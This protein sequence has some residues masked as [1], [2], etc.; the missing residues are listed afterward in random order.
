MPYGDL[1]AFLERLDQLGELHRIEAPVDTRYE[2]GAVCRRSVSKEGPALWFNQPRGYQFPVIANLLATRKR[3][4][5]ALETTPELLHT[6][7]LQRTQQSLPPRL[8][9]KGP[10]Q[11]V[12]LTGDQ[13]DLGILPVPIWNYLDG[14]PYITFPCQISKDP[15][16][17]GRNASMYRSQVH[18]KDAIGILSAPYRHLA[19]QRAR[20]GNQPFPVAIALG[21][22]PVIHIA[23]TAC[24]AYGVDELAMAGALAGVPV[25]LV[26]CVTIP[27]EVPASAEIVLEG[28]MLPGDMMEEGPFGEFTGYFGEKM[29]RPVIRIRAITHRRDAL[30][31]GSYVGKPPTENDLMLGIPAEAEVLRT[32]PLPGIKKVHLSHGGGG[33]MHAV[34]AL[35]QP[36]AGY[37]K[38]VGLSVLGTQPGRTMKTL[39]I[40]DADLDPFNQAEVRWALSTHVRP[41]HDVEIIRDLSGIVLDPSLPE[42]EK[43]SGDA[44]TSK[45]LIDA[46]RKKF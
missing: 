33:Y 22:D 28:E 35:E 39:I 34:V 5:L 31:L 36:F 29:S 11:E 9:D 1:R 41:E 38:T 2:L 17:G 20:A 25:D 43:R 8:V 46:T 45:M 30:Y 7:W 44:R 26:S 18:G 19:Q 13:V 21:L 12:V 37:A 14:G 42:A 15:V 6:E 40:I 32:T 16:T 4:A 10:C 23:A 3:F 27:L 24:F